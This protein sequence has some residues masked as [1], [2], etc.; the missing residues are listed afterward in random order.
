MSATEP[1]RGEG[2]RESGKETGEI[3][4]GNVHCVRVLDIVCIKLNYEHLYN[5]I[6]HRNSIK[7]IIY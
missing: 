5:C 7:E 3:S 1:D 6:Y 4:G 2:K